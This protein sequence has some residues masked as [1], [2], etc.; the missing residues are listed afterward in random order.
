MGATA[1][2]VLA[3]AVIGM[4][5]AGCGGSGTD[6]ERTRD[7]SLAAAAPMSATATTPRSTPDTP[8]PRTT[9]PTAS[10]AARGTPEPAN[11]PATPDR[12]ASRCATPTDA[13][14]IRA[15]YRG[16]PDDY[17]QVADIP[18]EALIEPDTGGRYRVERGEQMTVVTAA[19]LP[20]GW[21]RFYPQQTPP[22]SPYAVSFLQ[23][24][25]PVGT[26]YT[27]TPTED[28]AAPTLITF[29]L[30]AAR[31]FVRPRPD[32]KPELGD[33]VVTTVFQVATDTPRYNRLDTT[34]AVTTVGSYAFLSDP[35]DTTTAVATYEALRDGTTTAL[36]IHTSDA[37]GAS[38]AALY[39][40]VGAGDLVE[41]HVA[42]D[43]F[44][45]Y[46]VTEVNPDPPGAVPRKL[47]A[48]EWMTYAFT[49]CSGAV[50]AT[51]VATVDWAPSN[52]QSPLTVPIR[53][54][55]WQLTTDDWAGALENEVLLHSQHPEESYE[56]AAVRRHRLWREPDLPQGWQLGSA[57]VGYEGTDGIIAT[58][59]DEDGYIALT[60]QIQQLPT[61]GR[62][63]S[64]ST[65]DPRAVVS[66]TRIIDGHPAFV[67]YS[68]IDA[69]IHGT[70]VR[71]Y[72]RATGV[73]YLVLGEDPSL[74]G[75]NID[76]TIEIARSLYRTDGQ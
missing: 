3:L 36:L 15:V 32:G 25:Q 66:E 64:T 35:S 53:H 58:Y 7:G 46:Q 22:G 62:V 72:N 2:R 51:T 75:G 70:L 67:E 1:Y 4:L 59:F 41:W 24:I 17:A 11:S 9:R 60:L 54:G 5:L 55:P 74:R 43:C 34:G 63:W 56:I 50:P 33:V 69:R 61:L 12:P 71:I 45:R 39:D 10:P 48:V 6:A 52:I 19:A 42:D 28:E 18:A 30:T 68:P 47:L 26:T 73:E 14:C 57:G 38:Q 29:D 21:T 44:V 37:Y 49:G 40:A 23:L 65:A 13:D 8:L 16:A 27:F 20:V 31:P 76:A